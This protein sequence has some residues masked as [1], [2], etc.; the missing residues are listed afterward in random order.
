MAY[1]SYMDVV[2]GIIYDDEFGD[3]GEKT[4]RLDELK[5]GESVTV[6]IP[7]KIIFAGE[8]RITASVVDLNT[9]AVATSDAVTVT[10]TRITAMRN[11]LV[12][13]VAVVVPVVYAAVALVLTR[14]KSKKP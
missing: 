13:C 12:I 1:L 11:T 3:K 10:M 5:A 14:R 2:D 8:F 4:V 9:G 7:L 6:T